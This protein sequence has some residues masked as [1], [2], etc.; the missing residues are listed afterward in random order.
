MA[1]P[2]PVRGEVWLVALDPVAGHAQAGTR[3]AIVISTDRFNASAAGLAVIVPITRTR[4]NVPLRVRID[5]PEGGVRAVSFALC[6][7][8]RSASQEHFVERWGAVSPRTLSE[9]EDR[10]RLLL[11]L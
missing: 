6:E 8:I 3:P 11:E 1:A 2:R 5:P 9:L 7:A 4:R 10:L